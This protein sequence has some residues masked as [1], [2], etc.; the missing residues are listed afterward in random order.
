MATQSFLKEFSVNK[1]NAKRVLCGMK[2]SKPVSFSVDQRV[3][4]LNKEQI[5][6]FLDGCETKKLT[7]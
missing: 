4:V 7:R 2:A 3:T 1:R 6:K 5:A